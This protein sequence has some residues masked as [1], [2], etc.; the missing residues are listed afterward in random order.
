MRVPGFKGMVA[1]GSRD[2]LQWLGYRISRD[3]RFAAAT[4]RFWWPAIFGADPI[5]M[6]EDDQLPDY[7]AQLRAYNEQD[8]LISALAQRFELSGFSAK[9]LFTD[10]VMSKWYRHSDVTD[11]ILVESRAAELSTVGRGRLLG[12]EELDRKNL[13]AFGRTWRQWSAG[14]NAHNFS[15]E[16][17]LTGFRAPFSGFYG[18]IDSA[19]VVTRNRTITPLMSNLTESMASDL[20][21]QVVIQDFNRPHAERLL[22]NEV[23]RTSTSRSVIRKQ[24]GALISRALLREASDDETDQ[25]ASLV[26]DVASISRQRGDWFFDDESHCDTWSIWPG[27]ELTHDENRARY[28]DSRGMMRGWTALLHGIITS[29]EY[30][31]D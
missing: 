6:P 21:C 10:M 11:P 28:Q 26:V 23:E 3:Q 31:H 18:G 1:G 15:R 20:A 29:Y 7:D 30:L 22:F 25:M 27:E 16:T 9:A 13:A 8:K 17:A 19:A 12:P 24:I 2:S 14:P 4:V 5:T